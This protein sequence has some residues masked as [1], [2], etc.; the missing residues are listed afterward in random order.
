MSKK[1][2]TKAYIKAKDDMVKLPA[3]QGNG[4]LKYSVSIDSKGKMVRYSF[5]YINFHVCAKDNGR[6]LGYDNCHGYHHKHYMGK[7]ER[8][9][10]ISLE[11]IQDRFEREWEELHEKVKKQKSH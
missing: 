10:F 4:V 2:Q 7:E 8:V 3:K 6:V 9:D 1:N 11:D 5:A